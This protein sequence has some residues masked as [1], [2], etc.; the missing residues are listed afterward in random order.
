MIKK[1][2][3]LKMTMPFV[4]KCKEL[5]EAAKVTRRTVAEDLG[6]TYENI[7]RFE[8]GK[9]NNLTIACYYMW[10]FGVDPANMEDLENGC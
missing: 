9:N 4:R 10:N 6:C 5:R 8:N 2:I 7:R 3:Y 1:D